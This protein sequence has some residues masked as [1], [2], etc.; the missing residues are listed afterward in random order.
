M[1]FK[2]CSKNIKL[3][4]KLKITFINVVQSKI[5]K[6]VNLEDGSVLIYGEVAKTKSQKTGKDLYKAELSINISGRDYYSKEESDNIYKSIDIVAT[7]I[8]RI[9]K[10]DYSR[11]VRLRRDGGIKAKKI[12]KKI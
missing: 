7:E 4:D 5:G 2:I 8:L 3:S 9:I 12:L 10:K 6:I 1:N 11:G